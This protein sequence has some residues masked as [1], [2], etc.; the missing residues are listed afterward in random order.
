MGL[1]SC[2]TNLTITPTIVVETPIKP[3]HTS[4]PVSQ[5]EPTILI[6]EVLTG[7]E[8]NN[9]YEYIELYH[10]GSEEPIDIRGYSLW[11]KLSDDDPEKLVVQWDQHTL[12]P[13]LGSYLLGRKGEDI[14]EIADSTFDVSMIP[15]RGS[16][17][18]RLNNG[19][20]ID[21]LSW[22]DNASD[23]TEG[24][25]AKFNDRNLALERRPGGSAG[26]WSDTQDNAQDFSQT[27]PNPQNIDSGARPEFEEELN[28]TVSVPNTVG[29]GEEF[30]FT[31][32][33]QNNTKQTVNGTT[34]QFPLS[35]SATI[36]Q[37]SEEIIFLDHAKYWG[38]EDIGSSY[39][40]ILWEI[41]SLDAGTETVT[42][43]SVQAPWTYTDIFA[44][45]Y[46]VQSENWLHARFG[47]RIRVAVE[48]G[49]IPISVVKNLLNEDII[50]EGTATMF[51]GGYYAGGGN[52]KFY[53]EDESGG[54]QVWVP[55][56]EG[57][58]EIHL[59]DQVQV[60]GNL[61]VYRGAYEVVVNDP[62]DINVL[63][64]SMLN[65][66][67]NPYRLDIGNAVNDPSYAGALVQVEGIVTRNEEFSYSYEIDLIDDNGNI[68]TLYIDKLTQI[69]VEAIET[70]HHYIASGIL[71]IIDTNQQLYP[72]IQEDLERI[73]PPVLTL[74]IDAP[75]LATPGEE[76]TITLTALNYTSDVF[77]DLL[78]TTTLP[79]RGGI[80]LTSISEGNII[81]GNQI[82]W[83]I[84]ELTGNGSSVS[85]SYQGLL[86]TEDGFITIEEYSA[87]ADEWPETIEGSP[88]LI[89][90]GDSV[91]IWA[92]QGNGDRSPYLFKDVRTG[93]TVTAA[94][95]GLQGFWIQ[96]Q[97]PSD[98]PFTSSGL[99]IFT[100]EMEFSVTEGNKVLINGI[101]RETYQQTQVVVENPEDI[102]VLEIGGPL[103][104]AIP[105]DPPHNLSD[106]N[107][108]FESLEGMLVE[109]KEPV[110]VVGPT[111][112]YGEFVV[113]LSKHGI[114]RLWQGDLANNGLA[115]MVDDGNSVTHSD[116]SGLPFLV[117][118]GDKITGLLG[119]L[120][121]TY[122]QYKIEPIV[123][124]MITPASAAVPSL[125]IAD[126]QSFSIMTWNVENLFDFLDPHP[127]G[128]EKPSLREYKVSIAKVANTILSAGAPI[129]VGLQEVENI[130]ILADIAA[131]ESLERYGY[132]PYLIEG[133][134]SLLINNAYLVRNDI[135]R[136]VEIEQHIAPEGLTS[137]PPLRILVEIQTGSGPLRLHLL[138]NHF[139]SM[140]GGETVTEPRRTAQAEWNITVIDNILAEDPLAFI[141][142]L[143]DLNSFLDSL[144]LITLKNAGLKHV[145]ELDTQAEWYTYIYQGGS[146][147][148]DHILVSEGLFDLL[149]EVDILH[150]NAD[151]G[152]PEAGDES[153][154]G[155][156]DHDPV[157]AIFSI[158]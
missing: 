153:P 74:E 1:I 18:I 57:E 123:Q 6:S 40:V 109:I 134:S 4:T 36:I 27:T 64:T 78:I 21:S 124:P 138:N 26:N 80:Q 34:V 45:N 19:T 20:V 154:L 129:I 122:G 47:G 37:V 112:K 72:R 55:G 100:G 23:Y 84:P 147:I 130:D 121:Y 43:I 140:S 24:N 8:G 88:F 35:N 120:A 82:S 51:T 118:T 63:S 2:S 142:L 33:V 12:V 56:G 116:R 101:V 98:N 14:A 131:H 87:S 158:P 107:I 137:R 29:P 132:Q 32:T 86:N 3:T 5:D 69:N 46:S 114:N 150:V 103:P 41:G 89:F 75:I 135:A 133:T 106:A 42:T 148:L 110:T 60:S 16:L 9:S 66:E 70:G 54:I 59:G 83:S 95:P 102:E 92:I 10:T 77:T 53:L 81:H 91:P 38:L 157:I 50:I 11:Y 141:V 52:V 71:E 155:K 17:Q 61:T 73:F 48:G 65:P 7:I 156:S 113:V 108:Y 145:F 96:D 115:I 149:Q 93:G 152:I 25:P 105:L 90:L 126:D 30:S 125:D 49:V 85:V 117:N 62:S 99:F 143:G 151:F 119:P 97:K 58:V 127:S 146:Q 76:I 111:S 79:K 94:F 31:L 139:T 67:Q 44:E 28:I 15:Q 22:G 144:P 128:S 104:K 68:I 39:Q 13:P 136:V